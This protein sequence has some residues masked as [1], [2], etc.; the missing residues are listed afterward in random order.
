MEKKLYDHLIEEEKVLWTGSPEFIAMDK[1]NKPFILGKAAAVIAVMAAFVVYYMVQVAAG[2]AEMKISAF[3]IVAALTALVTLPEILDAN[4]LKKTLYAVTDRRLISIVGSNVESVEYCKIKQ[5][6][7]EEDAD[8]QV[9]LLCGERAMASKPR[10]RRL[11]TILGTR[12][13]EDKSTCDSFV[14]YGVPEADK[15]KKLIAK[16]I[17]A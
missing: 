17:A 6:A 3:V 15:V 12:L 10:L 13:T 8:G 2:A 14:F 9:S 4:K 1:T 11:Y 5:Y 16:Y 7:F